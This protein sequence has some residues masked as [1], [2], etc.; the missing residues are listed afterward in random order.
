MNQSAFNSNYISQLEEVGAWEHDS[1]YAP[2]PGYFHSPYTTPSSFSPSPSSA[3]PAVQVGRWKGYDEYPPTCIHYL[4]EWRVTVNNQVVAKD[5][6]E[7]L[8]LAPS[9]FW[10]LFLEEK[11]ENVLRRK[12]ARK[13]QVRADDTAIVV[14]KWGSGAR[15]P[16]ES[17]ICN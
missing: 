3:A 10:Q 13:G 15:G 14:L 11:L 7:D 4:I 6:E 9:A 2:T 5:T 8:V 16:E 17:I 1:Q 12:V